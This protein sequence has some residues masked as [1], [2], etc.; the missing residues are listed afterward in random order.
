MNIFEDLEILT[1]TFK[2]EH[3][4]ENCLSTIDTN[5]KVTIVENSNNS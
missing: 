1:V 5:F 2:S 3:I 4:I